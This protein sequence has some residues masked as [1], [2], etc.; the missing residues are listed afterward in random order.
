MATVIIIVIGLLIGS[1]LLG[2]VVSIM[3]KLY[4]LCVIIWYILKGV[5]HTVYA[6]A[7]CI[8]LPFV[9]LWRLYK[10]LHSPKIPPV[11]ATDAA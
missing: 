6:I 10:R 3:Q 1:V 2:L 11:P 9:G 8:V 7:K 4:L 5:C